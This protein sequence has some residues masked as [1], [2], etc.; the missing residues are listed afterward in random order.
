MNETEIEVA[1]RNALLEQLHQHF[2]SATENRCLLWVD[3]AQEDPFEGNPLV[4]ETRIRTPIRHLRFDPQRG[5]YVVPLDLSRSAEADLFRDSVELAC[6]SWS[7]DHLNA[8]R[9]QPICGWVSVSTGAKA[10]AAHWGWRCHLHIR[11]REAKL[12]RFQDPGVREWLWP[13]LNETQQRAM[14]GPATAI[15]AIGRGQKLIHHRRKPGNDAASSDDYPAL[16]LN[17]SQWDQ[18]DHYAVVHAAWLTWRNSPATERSISQPTGWERHILD[19]LDQASLVGV[20]DAAD[21]ELFALHAL[22]LGAGFHQAPQLREVWQKT[23][24]GEF[25]GSAVEEVTGEAAAQLDKFLAKSGA[26]RDRGSYA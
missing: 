19:A 3:P 17:Q 15:H 1:P 18:L 24:A 16:Q 26:V 12:L 13:V 25:Y 10:V 20:R 23:M 11:P 22:Q 7:S 8:M 5:P 21:R 6:L 4:E 14:L 9:G 2:Y